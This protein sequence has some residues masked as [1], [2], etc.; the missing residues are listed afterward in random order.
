[1]DAPFPSIYP[2]FLVNPDYEKE[3]RDRH[4][5]DLARAEC[6]FGSAQRAALRSAHA[7][8]VKYETDYVVPKKVRPFEANA[9]NRHVLQLDC[10]NDKLKLGLEA[11]GRQHDEVVPHFNKNEAGLAR[12]KA[13]DAH[14]RNLCE[15]YQVPLIIAPHQ[16]LETVPAANLAG[17]PPVA[18]HAFLSS[19]LVR[20]GFVTP[21]PV[22]SP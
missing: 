12:Q 15:E 16:L 14:K 22:T 6:L 3:M 4:A 19:E 21:K 17:V 5:A 10:F 7:K 9:T 2:N 8:N 20:L 1:M 18:L 11:N 13:K